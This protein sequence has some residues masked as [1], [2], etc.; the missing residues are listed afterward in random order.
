MMDGLL[1]FKPIQ[2]QR[3]ETESTLTVYAPAGERVDIQKGGTSSSVSL[4]KDWWLARY[5]TAEM[6]LSFTDIHAASLLSRDFGS[7]S[8]AESPQEGMKTWFATGMTIVPSKTGAAR[9]INPDTNLP[10]GTV[11][12][13]SIT[14]GE[15]LAS[16]VGYCDPYQG[17]NGRSDLFA[18]YSD[19]PAR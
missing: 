14:N 12:V 1:R 8:G 7:S 2:F 18:L 15:R 16:C 13:I 6:S 10:W 3:S 19:C 17:T 5:N 4:K 9:T 11:R